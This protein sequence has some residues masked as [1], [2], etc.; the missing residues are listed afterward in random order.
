MLRSDSPTAN[1]REI[2]SR[3]ESDNH[4]GDYSTAG[5]GRRNPPDTT[6]VRIV[7]GGRPNRRLIDRNDS[8]A[9]NLSHNSAFSDSDNRRITHLDNEKLNLPGFHA[10]SVV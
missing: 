8:P 7:D 9:S 10:G 6:W 5:N 4:T 2:S 1:P 3:S